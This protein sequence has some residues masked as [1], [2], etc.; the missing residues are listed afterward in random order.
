MLSVKEKAKRIMCSL[1][2]KK[3]SYM[4]GPDLLDPSVLR[5]FHA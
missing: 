2:I 3:I 5:L 4:S 1:F